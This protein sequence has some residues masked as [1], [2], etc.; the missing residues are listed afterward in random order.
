M[1]SAPIYL[2][3]QSTTPLAPEVLEAMLPYFRQAYGNPHS[4]EHVFGWQAF[5][6]L[7]NA[8]LE[9]AELIG[10]E[11]SDIIFTSG[12]T[13]SVSLAIQGAAQSPVRGGQYKIITVATE[14]ACV[15]ASCQ[16]MRRHG[17][18]SNPVAG[19]QRWSG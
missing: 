13:E 12:A 3:N 7:E 1:S 17:Y 4:G 14:H 11:K 2:D 5:S 9:V 8:R 15:L 19:R 18:G 6:A 16:Q 10:A